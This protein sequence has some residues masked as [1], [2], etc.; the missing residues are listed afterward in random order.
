MKRFVKSA[1]NPWDEDYTQ[2]ITDTLVRTIDLDLSGL[3]IEVDE[4]SIE[5]SNEDWLSD[6]DQFGF[7]TSVEDDPQIKQLDDVDGVADKVI[8]LLLDN[9]FD[10]VNRYRSYKLNKCYVT[11]SYDVEAEFEATNRGYYTRQG[12]VDTLE[13]DWNKAN[14]TVECEYAR[15]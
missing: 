9:V 1:I 6:A 11:L 8:E 7:F 2:V 12:D 3:E 13:V 14:S 10:H 5:F 4:D 15:L